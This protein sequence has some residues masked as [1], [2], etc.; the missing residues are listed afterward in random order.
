MKK[1]N[2]NQRFE[3]QKRGHLFIRTHTLSV[4]TMRTNIVALF[5]LEQ[6]KCFARLITIHYHLSRACHAVALVKAGG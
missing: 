1:S 3:L 6:G 4:A 5:A 2:M